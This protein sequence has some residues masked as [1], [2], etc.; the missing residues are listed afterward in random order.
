[1]KKLFLRAGVAVAAIPLALVVLPGVALA[2][3]SSA[4]CTGD[5]CSVSADGF[6]GGTISI[7]ADTGGSG[8]ALWGLTG[9]NGFR[10]STTFT[11]AGGVRS[12]TCSRAPAGH[13][14]ATVAGPAGPAVIGIRW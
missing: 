14:S 6:P 3:G 4:S 10:C 12:W 2:T 1:V 9:P 11:A 13:Y 5:S 7:D 8:T